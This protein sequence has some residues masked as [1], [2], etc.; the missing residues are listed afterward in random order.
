MKLN[1][2]DLAKNLSKD[3]KNKGSSRLI[4]RA[5]TFEAGT[6]N[7]VIAAIDTTTLE[8]G[9]ITL[10]FEA[11]HNE[12]H[13][14]VLF[15]TNFGGDGLSDGLEALLFGL[16]GTSEQALG[17]WLEV[18]SKPEHAKQAFEMLRGMKLK[19]EIG[20]TSGFIIVNRNGKYYAVD[21]KTGE[22]YCGPFPRRILAKRVA[23]DQ[24]LKE[25]KSL[26]L[27]AED[28]HADDNITA[29]QNCIKAIAGTEAGRDNE[30]VRLETVK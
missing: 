3:M 10:T 20:E 2:S 16:F 29:L 28:T 27:D 17:S 23:L 30:P 11:Q 6:Y 13:K 7:V 12:Q 8:S 19:I 24:Q 15:L 1:I 4:R 5:G 21:N 18:L 26:I 9:K 14:Q 25:P 22:E